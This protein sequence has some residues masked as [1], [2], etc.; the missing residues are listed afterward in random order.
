MTAALPTSKRER[1]VYL[2]D[3]WDDIHSPPVSGYGRSTGTDTPHLSP[4]SRHASV[5]ELNRC[6]ATLKLEHKLW[7]DHLKAFHGAEWGINVRRSTRKRKGGKQEQIIL[8]DR[9][10]RPPSWVKTGYVNSGVFRLEEL[11]N[12]QVFIPEPLWLAL[13]KSS[14]EIAELERVRTRPRVAA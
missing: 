2:L 13:T 10:R 4:M 11:F 1:I 14:A 3:H 5:V 8:R 9:I 7:H 6:L 12:G